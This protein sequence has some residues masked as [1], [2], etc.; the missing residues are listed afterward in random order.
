VRGT[1]GFFLLTRGPNTWVTIVG[2]EEER[3][4]TIKSKGRAEMFEKILYPTDFSNVS[5]KAEEG[6]GIDQAD[7]GCLVDRCPS[8]G[9]VR[10]WRV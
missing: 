1:E 3:E 6:P 4:F 2:S 9:P 7:R 10:I 5:R 8:G